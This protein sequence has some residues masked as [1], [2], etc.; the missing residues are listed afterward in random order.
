MKFSIDFPLYGTVRAHLG[1]RI[2]TCAQFAPVPHHSRIAFA[3]NDGFAEPSSFDDVAIWRHS[4]GRLWCE[5]DCR[6]RFP[7]CS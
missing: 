3:G 5:D 6:N 1:A 2:R 7:P 4:A